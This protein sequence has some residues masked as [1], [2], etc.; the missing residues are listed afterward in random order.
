ML[1]T[2]GKLLLELRLSLQRRGAGGDVI[3]AAAAVTSPQR[4]AGQVSALGT[5]QYMKTTKLSTLHERG[6]GER[7]QPLHLHAG[8]TSDRV[9]I[10]PA[11]AKNLRYESRLE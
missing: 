4:R 6:A 5:V 7:P 9:S 10:Y 11:L 3:I 1:L 8:N 2:A